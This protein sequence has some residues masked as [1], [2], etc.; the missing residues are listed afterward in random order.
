M[1]LSMRND[2]SF[3]TYAVGDLARLSGVSIRTLHHY[4]AIGLL[5]P[6][7]VGE[8]GYRLYGRA[9]LMRLQQILLYRELGLSLADIS[10]VLDDPGYDRLDALYRQRAHLTR[11]AARFRRLIQT[12]DRTIAELH[13]EMT[14]TDSDIYKGFAPAKQA[15]YENWL[16]DRFGENARRN[17][18]AGKQRI[19]SLTADEMKAHLD[20]LGRIESDLA[21]AF[22]AGTPADAASLTS[23]LQRHHDW[24][25]KSWAEPPKRDAYAGLG[26]LYASHPDFRARYEGMAPGLA[27]WLRTA[28]AEFAARLPAGRD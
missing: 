21:S 23:L 13:G 28:M 25:A 10:A 11:E 1:K 17:I 4:D 12:I 7:S 15:E 18:A 24:T 22:R 19:S 16:N 8:N 9:E 3:R 26:E 14:M 2:A 5:K 20:E 27:D 6:A